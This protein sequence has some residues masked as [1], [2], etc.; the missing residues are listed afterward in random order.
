MIPSALLAALQAHDQLVSSEDAAS[1]GVTADTLATLR[2]RGALV[3]VRRGVYTTAEHWERTPPGPARELLRARAASAMMVEPHVFS[4][5][6]AAHAWGLTF[7]A[8]RE[9]MVHVTR[10]RVLG[11]RS[12]SGVKH[13]KAPYE[14]GQ[15]V[16]TPYGPALDLARTA[17]DLTREHGLHTGL[18]AC[19]AALRR[20]V[21]REQLERAAGAMASWRGVNAIREAVAMADPGA[22]NPAESLTRLLVFEAG[23]GLPTTQFPVR[24]R[25]TVAWCD[26]RVGR[27]LIEF[28]G[29]LKYRRTHQGGVATSDTGDVVWEER[30][31]ERGLIAAGWGVSRLVWDDVL[32]RNW[33]RTRARL[34]REIGLT[35]ARTG[36][37]PTAEQQAFAVRM[38]PVR[39][40]RIARGRTD[41]VRYPV[42]P[43]KAEAT[44]IAGASAE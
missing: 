10:E 24:L 44:C 34:V 1:A 43:Q 35:A 7:L 36:M 6:S 8:P 41:P 40:R 16:H 11:S 25:E 17:C 9:P 29:R 15:V 31:R 5:D 33:E 22:E 21:M 38:E 13:H 14:T 42:R 27:H 20:G 19:D 18:T 28:D 12:R 4:H 39:Q 26:V 3:R 37:E 2:R 32:A 23:F 30:Q